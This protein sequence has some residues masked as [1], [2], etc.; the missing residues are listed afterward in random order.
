MVSR[1]VSGDVNKKSRSSRA[2][3]RARTYW[4]AKSPSTMS[5]KVA[6][7]QLTAQAQS[8]SV[9]AIEATQGKKAGFLKQINGCYRWRCLTLQEP[10]SRF[11]NKLLKFQVC[12]PQLSPKRRCSPT[13]VNN[14]RSAGPDQLPTAQ[15]PRSYSSM[16]QFDTSFVSIYVQQNIPVYRLSTTYKYVPA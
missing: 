12:S 5:Q 11:G 14:Y 16:R 3:Q 1:L 7:T 8:P 13:R 2:H 10:Q 6:G 9:A 4:P 15:T